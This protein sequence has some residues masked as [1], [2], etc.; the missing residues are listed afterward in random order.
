MRLPIRPGK[1]TCAGLVVIFMVLPNSIW[2][3]PDAKDAPVSKVK[4]ETR[5]VKKTARDS[6][7]PRVKFREVAR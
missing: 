2:K 1:V 3:G 7:R 5:K 6:H 4:V